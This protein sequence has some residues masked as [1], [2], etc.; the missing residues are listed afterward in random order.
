MIGLLSFAG[1]FARVWWQHVLLGGN[2]SSQLRRAGRVFQ[3]TP[4]WT[5]TVPPAVSPGRSAVGPHDKLCGRS[6]PTMSCR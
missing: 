4:T 1:A 6:L 3:P 2:G 5:L